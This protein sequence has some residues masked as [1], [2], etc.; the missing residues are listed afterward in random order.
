MF[1]WL[2]LLVMLFYA[3]VR[4]L[5]EVRDRAPL[6]PPVLVALLCQA[7]FFYFISSLQ[8]KPAIPLTSPWFLF[9]VLL[10]AAGLLLLVAIIFAPFVIFMANV[11]ERRGSFRLVIQQ[12]YVATLSTL[13]Y[14]LGGGRSCSYP[15]C[16][17]G[18]RHGAAGHSEPRARALFRGA[19][20]GIAPQP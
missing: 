9:N 2:R 8:Q 20:E 15:T 4:A 7:A 13:S 17:S 12:E 10:Q 3:P 16:F 14:A 1:D 6:A 18:A 5:S 11:F 19:A